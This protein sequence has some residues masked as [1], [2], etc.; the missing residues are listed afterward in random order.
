M[1]DSLPNV[2]NPEVLKEKMVFLIGYRWV[3]GTGNFIALTFRL[4][5][6]A[7]CLLMQADRN[8]ENIAIKSLRSRKCSYKDGIGDY[9]LLKSIV[10]Q[11]EDE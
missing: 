7:H 1:L 2:K 5:N 8:I 10:L 3:T 11:G 4:C 6:C 9:Q